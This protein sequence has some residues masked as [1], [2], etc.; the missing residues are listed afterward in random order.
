MQDTLFAIL[1][2]VPLEHLE[3]AQTIA[4]DVPYISFGSQKWELFRA[5]DEE[6]AGSPVPVLIYPSHDEHR[7]ESPYVVEWSGWYVSSTDD[8]SKKYRDQRDGRRPPT[9]AQCTTD[10]VSH[11]AVFWRVANL[12]RLP[13]E[14][15]RPISELHSYRSGANR[16]AGAPR[17]P[18]RIER[19]SDFDFGPQPNTHGGD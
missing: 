1:A 19:P 3:S 7:S 17:G 9:T 11:W 16:K 10:T 2:P 13:R 5:I 14:K 4:G 15:K 18:E 6:R 12:T 8:N